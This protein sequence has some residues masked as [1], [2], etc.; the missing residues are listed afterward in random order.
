MSKTNTKYKYSDLAEKALARHNQK[1]PDGALI[2]KYQN[3]RKTFINNIFKD[4]KAGKV[5]RLQTLFNQ[6]FNQLF[7]NV[8][9]Y[10][11][12]YD[13][14]ITDNKQKYQ[15][16]TNSSDGEIQKFCLKMEQ[17]AERDFIET[18]KASR[19]Y[20]TRF[21]KLLKEKK[22]LET[23]DSPE[24]IQIKRNIEKKIINDAIGGN[25]INF[26]G[27]LFEKMCALVIAVA[28]SKK[29]ETTQEY[30]DKI[31]TIFQS[32]SKTVPGKGP[33]AIFNEI[34]NKI[35]TGNVKK[36]VTGQALGRKFTVNSNQKSDL[37]FDMGDALDKTTVGVSLKTSS[38]QTIN[39]VSAMN[40]YKASQ[41]WTKGDED[42]YIHMLKWHNLS[43]IHICFLALLGVQ[44]MLGYGGNVIPSYFMIYHM[45]REEKPFEMFPVKEHLKNQFL[46]ATT[47]GNLPPYFRLKGV[48]Q[49]AYNELIEDLKNNHKNAN[50]KIIRVLQKAT[51]EMTINYNRLKDKSSFKKT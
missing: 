26:R 37:V 36:N 3:I 4:V 28:Q 42:F 11:R 32:Y 10:K 12:I 51:L 18:L 49:N 22:V 16:I 20:Q 44:G 43:D 7:G 45:N 30:I 38:S 21:K 5:K 13:A 41:E 6:I 34:A 27:L 24:A 31:R 47:I 33:M 14:V 9:D 8:E 17:Q 29:Y 1:V 2:D 15:H 19:N 40:I 23:D 39:L 46:N 50:A 48:A 35:N 25:I